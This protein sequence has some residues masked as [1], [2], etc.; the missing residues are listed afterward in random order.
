MTR[1]LTNTNKRTA[2]PTP[3]SV[4]VGGNYRLVDSSYFGAPGQ[5]R[6]NNRQTGTL[7]SRLDTPGTL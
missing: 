2:S 7:S 1:R 3:G 6:S 5:P 4:R